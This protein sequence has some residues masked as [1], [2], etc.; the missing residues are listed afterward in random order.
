MLVI[1]FFR[2]DNSDLN[3][4]MEIK[5]LELS[6]IHVMSI[7]ESDG[8]GERVKHSWLKGC[9]RNFGRKKDAQNDQRLL[10]IID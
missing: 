9:G 5:N 7:I 4:E 2:R 10:C 6:N 8:G 1:G 3:N